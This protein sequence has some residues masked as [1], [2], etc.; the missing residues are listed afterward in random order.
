MADC[1]IMTYNPVRAEILCG[2]KPTMTQWVIMLRSW[3]THTELKYSE[4]HGFMSYSATL[5]EGSKGARFKYIG[6]SGPYW[7]EVKVSLTDQQEDWA[8]EKAESRVGTPYDLAG[9]LCHIS[10]LKFWKPDPNKT[11]CTKE[12]AECLYAA[13]GDFY[14]FMKKYSLTSELRPDML[15][16]MARYYFSPPPP[17]T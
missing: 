1:S 2:V 15:D 9:Q 5:M 3:Q 10:K 8:W 14:E 13:R 4:R 16:M 17:L 6:Y 11:W 12:V 7:D